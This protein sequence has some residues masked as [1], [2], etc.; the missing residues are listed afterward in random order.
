MTQSK[1]NTEIFKGWYRKSWSRKSAVW[2]RVVGVN[3]VLCDSQM[4]YT[5]CGRQIP[6]TR[7]DFDIKP[8]PHLR[9]MQCENFPGIIIKTGKAFV[10][11][12]ATSLPTKKAAITELQRLL[13]PR[14]YNMA[15]WKPYGIEITAKWRSDVS[16]DIAT[17]L[18]V[19]TSR[20]KK[21]LLTLEQIQADLG[22]FKSAIDCLC[23]ASDSLAR[24]AKGKRGLYG[25]L[26]T[27]ESQTYFEK[28]MAEVG[29]K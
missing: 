16:I 25:R 8:D 24:Q 6:T 29:K 2:H 28:L 10:P 4:A 18:T 19:I 17:E 9:C 11:V 12:G 23:D 22:L 7:C 27:E 14:I 20:R 3:S 5:V 13:K 15:I 21:K 1:N 26:T